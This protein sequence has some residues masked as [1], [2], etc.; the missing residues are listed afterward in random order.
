MTTEADGSALSMTSNVEV[1]GAASAAVDEA[2]RLMPR[3]A[4]PPCEKALF[5][6][7]SGVKGD[8]D[9]DKHDA[10]HGNGSDKFHGYNSLILT[11]R[12]SILRCKTTIPVLSKMSPMTTTM[13]S[14]NLR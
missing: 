11:M 1:C 13:P 5:R 3:P 9:D 2:R 6:S 10:E 8:A 7:T 14:Q 12:R 4:T